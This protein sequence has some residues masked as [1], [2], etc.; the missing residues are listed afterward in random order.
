MVL[1]SNIEAMPDGRVCWQQAHVIFI[2]IYAQL[3]IDIIKKA[4][5]C[6]PVAKR[7]NNK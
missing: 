5:L 4:H 6:I 1:L 2:F 7:N 3:C